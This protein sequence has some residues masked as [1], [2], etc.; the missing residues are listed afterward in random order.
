MNFDFT[1]KGRTYLMERSGC[2]EQLAQIRQAVLD[3]G[4][5]RG[6]RVAEFVNGSGLNF[7]VNLDRGMDIAEASYRGIP[8]A[9]ISPNRPVAPA[10][11]EPEGLGWLR[12]WGGGLL[13]GCGLRNV[14]NPGPA[15]A[16][17]HGLHGRLSHI[18]AEDVAVEKK[19]IDG[20]YV[21]SISGWVKQTAV[22]F[23]NLHL[24]RKIS[25]VMGQNSIRVEDIVE[26]HGF[27]VSPL[28]LLY[29]I[30]LGFPLLDKD[31]YLTAASHEAVPRDGIA[32]MGHKDWQK[33][34]APQPGYKEQ[35]F[36]HEIPAGHD[37]FAA[38]TLTNPAL[39]LAFQL[40][41]RVA[42]LPYLIQW[43]QMGQGEYVLG[44]EPANCHP[45]GQNSERQRGTLR[46][47]A[48]GQ[49]ISTCLKLTVLET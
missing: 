22:F 11:Y 19:W 7:T 40:E 30:N 12:T 24:K 39:K 35:V 33:S 49:S 4:R 16:E 48:P 14:G 6:S 15:G 9:W 10:F 42:E 34:E 8:L 28:M 21:Q 1:T 23:E 25:S 46:E 29:H 20:Y 47:L 3:D 38:V 17:T 13:T 44:L 2:V 36:Y 31:A 27:A 5:G 18:P 45:E 41:Y 37:G 43:K 26:N 32:A